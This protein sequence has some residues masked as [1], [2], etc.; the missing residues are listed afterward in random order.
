MTFVLREPGE[1]ISKQALLTFLQ[2]EYMV[3]CCLL[4]CYVA[5]ITNTYVAHLLGAALLCTS[6]GQ[7]TGIPSWHPPFSSC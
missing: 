6:V 4:R 7:K 2:E 5:H 3:G 1:A